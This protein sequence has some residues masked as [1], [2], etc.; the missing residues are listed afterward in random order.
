MAEQLHTNTNLTSVST[1][2]AD[3]SR[4]TASLPD[5]MIPAVRFSGE[6]LLGMAFLAPVKTNLETPAHQ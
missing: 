4:V 6:E 1:L 3:A 5:S 2:K